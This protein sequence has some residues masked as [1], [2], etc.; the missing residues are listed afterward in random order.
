MYMIK[1]DVQRYIVQVTVI[2]EHVQFQGNISYHARTV[3][4]GVRR[5]TK[6]L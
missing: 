2:S 3:S 1:Q 6:F 4:R 5:T